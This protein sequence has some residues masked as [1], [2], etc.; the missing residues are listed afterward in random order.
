MGSN[1]T[2]TDRGEL[3]SMLAMAGMFVV[4]ILLGLVIRPFY[5]ANQLQ[6]FGEAGAT[7]VRFI[8]L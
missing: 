3:L 8:L 4:T 7:Q 1:E 6:D 2:S 5:D